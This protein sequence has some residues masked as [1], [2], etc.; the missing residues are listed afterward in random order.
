MATI[1]GLVMVWAVVVVMYHVILSRGGDVLQVFFVKSVN[2]SV[3]EY[4]RGPDVSFGDIGLN[5]PG[6]GRVQL[7]EKWFS[8]R[9]SF[10]SKLFNG[11]SGV[12]VDRARGTVFVTNKGKV[13]VRAYSSSS[14]RLMFLISGLREPTGVALDSRTA[15]SRCLMHHQEHLWPRL[16]LRGL[17]RNSYGFPV[18]WLLIRAESITCDHMNRVQVWSSSYVF[19]RSI[20]AAGHLRAPVGIALDPLTQ[21]VFVVHSGNKRV[22]AFSPDGG[23]LSAFG[24]FVNPVG[25]AVDSHSTVFLADSGSVHMFPCG[26]RFRPTL[27]SVTP[28]HLKFGRK[29]APSCGIAS[30]TTLYLCCDAALIACF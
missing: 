6:H 28:L 10:P 8:V 9:K 4:V 1:A 27:T 20:R 12:A 26:T 15:R 2:R 17:P 22:A 13:R 23:F 11:T 24:H 14:G 3:C 29:F 16:D 5:E 7:L 19:L 18:R 21:N 25:V 30:I